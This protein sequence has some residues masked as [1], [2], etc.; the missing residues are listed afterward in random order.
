MNYDR[1]V[2]YSGYS[3]IIKNVPISL[4]DPDLNTLFLFVGNW[5]L[6]IADRN[7][8]VEFQEIWDINLKES[9]VPGAE[10]W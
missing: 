3:F 10:G 6:E 8:T 2:E 5:Q 7:F 1:I 9:H 4:S